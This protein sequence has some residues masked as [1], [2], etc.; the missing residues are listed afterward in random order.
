M[1]SNARRGVREKRVI[2]SREG[3]DIRV[4]S[5]SVRRSLWPLSGVFYPFTFFY[6]CWYSSHATHAP[7]GETRKRKFDGVPIIFFQTIKFFSQYKD[8]KENEIKNRVMHSL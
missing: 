2:R 6:H 5:P 8:L 4:L 7:R 3:H 1:E